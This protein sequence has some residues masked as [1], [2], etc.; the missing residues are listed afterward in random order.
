MRL[1]ELRPSLLL[2]DF[3]LIQT[4]F[5]LADHAIHYYKQIDLL[6][7]NRIGMNF[8]MSLFSLCIH[9]IVLS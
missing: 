8:Q 9:C 1:M 4:H 7:D 5:M 2:L 3:F 6:H